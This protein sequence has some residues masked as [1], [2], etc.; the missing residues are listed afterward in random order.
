MK[1]NL[2]I[3]MQT[4]ECIKVCLN[5]L[6]KKRSKPAG[7]ISD[8]LEYAAFLGQLHK[9]FEDNIF[10]IAEVID[11]ISP[12]EAEIRG[13]LP[14]D[15]LNRA[16]EGLSGILGKKFACLAETPVPCVIRTG[17]VKLVS[18]GVIGHT[19]ATRWAFSE[20]LE[21]HEADTNTFSEVNYDTGTLVSPENQLDTLGVAVDMNEGSPEANV[22]EE[23]IESIDGMSDGFTDAEDAESMND[24]LFNLERAFCDGLIKC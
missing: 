21:E 3:S 11:K 14:R 18:K 22:S 17:K 19:K 2:D 7:E 10:T 20:I 15:L 5:A 9:V 24:L 23:Q 6:V 12:N 13:F 1:A 16:P 8:E 4:Y